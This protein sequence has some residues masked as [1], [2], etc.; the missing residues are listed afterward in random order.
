VV[1]QGLPVLFCLDRAGLVGGDG[2]VH[3][4]FLD[5][6]Y[7]RSFPGMV[8]MAP[9]DEAEL[10]EAMRFAL[11]LNQPAAI[12]YPRDDVPSA[13][14]GGSECPPFEMGVSRELRAGGDAT[15]LAYG[16]M[17]VPALE[18]AG[19]LSADGIEVR[20]INARFARPLDR[21]MVAEAFAGG[22]A[23]VTVEDHCVNGGFGSAVLE[24][25]QELG[26]PAHRSRR[27]GIPGDR[28]VAHGSRNGQLAEV[29]L[30]S[31]GIAA[32]VQ[33][34]MSGA[35]GGEPHPAEEVTARR[36]RWQSARDELLSR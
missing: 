11:P 1:L 22:K 23:V 18:A 20:V 6:A 13:P 32:A 3:H 35:R 12:R 17:T 27:L 14:V 7:L 8:L 28:F 33:R 5:I 21:A 34:L 31:A 10:R 4:G 9:S 30:D 2:A 25:A 26:L 36:K 19:M 15:I 24:V 29:G 16:T